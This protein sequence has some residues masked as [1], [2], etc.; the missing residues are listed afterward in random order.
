MAEKFVKV[1]TPFGKA[2]FPKLNEPDT[3]YKAEG[4]YCVKLELSGADAEDLVEKI[5]E[6][7]EAGYERMLQEQREKKK[8]PGLKKLKIA[9]DGSKPY[10]LKEDEDGNEIEGVYIFNLKTK[11][12]G[13]N[14][15]TGKRWERRP[16]LVDSNGKPV[17]ATITGGSTLRCHAELFPWFFPI[18]YGLS[19]RLSAVQVK[20]LA[21]YSQENPFDSVEGGY[22]EEEEIDTP[23]EDGDAD[24]DTADHEGD[25]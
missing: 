18:G 3:K 19:L 5:D 25:F 17:T 6:A 23:F 4:E 9:A 15:K 2:I 7:Y 14:K 16:L 8:K 21:T 13:V 11:A 12:S 10:K 20:E 22:T 1:I 24:D